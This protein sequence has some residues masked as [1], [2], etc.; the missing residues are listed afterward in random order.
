VDDLSE[1]VAYLHLSDNNGHADDHQPPGSRGGI[2]R[3]H[4]EY[5]MEVL[6]KYDN[7][8]T[9]SFEM[10]PSMPAVMLRQA[11]DFIFNVLRW[12]NRPQKQH[13]YSDIVYNPA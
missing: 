9:A 11:S 4:W 12:P 1:R 13:G 8:V 5:L 3:K 2:A 10:C 6:S 7:D